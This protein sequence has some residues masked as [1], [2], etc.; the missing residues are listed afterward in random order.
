MTLTQQLMQFYAPFAA[1]LGV[2]FWL[3]VL[4]Q[5]VRDLKERVQKM[6]EGDAEGGMIDRM[7]RLEVNGENATKALEKISREM[8]GL[9][10]QMGN[11]FT[12]NPQS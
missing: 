2:V 8:E 7:A 3:G 5:T 6:E 4:T 1:L 9:Q 11:L 12:R 10:R